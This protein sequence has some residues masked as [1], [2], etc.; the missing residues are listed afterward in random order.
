MEQDL[1]DKSIE[2]LLGHLNEKEKKAKTDDVVYGVYDSTKQ[3]FWVRFNDFLVDRS[4]VNLKE[5]SYFFHLMAVMLDS[6]IPILK[7]LQV[8]INKVDNPHFRRV[9]NT[10]A[11]DVEHGKKLSDAMSKF[12]QVFSDAEVG[13]VRSGESVGNLESVL[14]KL[15]EQLE[16]TYALYLKVKGALVYPVVV[17]LALVV[18]LWIVLTMVIPKLED[19][20]LQSDV[21]LPWLTLAV[22]SL[23]RFVAG[24][25]WFILLLVLLGFALWSFWVNTRMGKVKW[26]RFKLNLPIFGELIR[27][28]LVSKLVRMMGVLLHAG[29]PINKTLSILAAASGNELYKMKLTDVKH[30]VEKGEK[31]SENLADTPFLFTETVTQ[32]LQIGEQSASLGKASEKVADHYEME[33][34]HA[35]KNMTTMLEPVIIILVGVAVAIVALAILGPIFSLSDVV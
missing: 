13:V 11:Y 19:F 17:L 8:L 21:S 24:Y 5:K 30:A 2:E 27:K 1:K 16:K 23:S 28:S 15:S 26:D 25:W 22:L 31:V 10:L 3:P 33:V 6:G 35:V 34:D 7:T 14:F 20:F 12:P 18:A 29:L 32:M 4:K 9:V